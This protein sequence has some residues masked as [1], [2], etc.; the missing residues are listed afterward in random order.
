MKKRI[1]SYKEGLTILAI[2]VDIFLINLAAGLSFWLRFKGPAPHFN[3]LAYLNIAP[4]MTGMICVLY[5]IFDLYDTRRRHSRLE[6][7]LNLLKAS[8]LATIV[9]V[10]FA[11]FYRQF[12]FPRLVIVIFYFLNIL[13]AGLWHSLLIDLDNYLHYLFVE[14]RA[15][16][17]LLL[18]G[19]NHEGQ[20]IARE[21]LKQPHREINIVGFLDDQEEKIKIPNLYF[22]GKFEDLREV[23]RDKDVDEV[24]FVTPALSPRRLIEL[25][26]TCLKLDVKFMVVPRLVDVALGKP[27][28][29]DYYNIPVVDL[30]IEPVKGWQA[31]LKRIIDITCS[32]IGFLGMLVLMPIIALAHKVSSPGP[33][34]YRQE[35]CGR[36]G[37]P[38]TLLKFRTMPPEAETKTGPVWAARI[39]NRVTKFGEFLRRTH[40][41]ELPQVINILKGEMSIVGPRP[42]RPEF[43]GPFLDTILFYK[44]RLLIAPGLTGWAQVNQAADESIEDVQKKLKYDLFYIENMSVFFDV[45]IIIRTL[46]TVFSHAIWK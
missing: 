35:R 2:L 19:A 39:D 24:I 44:N 20:D 9:L 25:L 38:F 16:R 14:R 22:L 8:S 41:D 4:F 30:T 7:I 18:V 36:D 21:L 10:T 43:A 45:Q 42:E 12:S 34:F 13:F 29:H 28:Y 46:P 27:K 11:F 40:I 33:L 1:I 6:T 31:N 32:F 5:Y 23:I 15:K 26:E 17:R 37:K 3:Y